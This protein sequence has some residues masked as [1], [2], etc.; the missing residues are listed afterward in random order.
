[1]PLL[2]L[3]S[4]NSLIGI[5]LP[6]EPLGASGRGSVHRDHC[7]PHVGIEPGYKERLDYGR[8]RSFCICFCRTLCLV[9]ELL[10]F[11]RG[12]DF[13]TFKEHRATAVPDRPGGL[14][15]CIGKARTDVYRGLY[16]LLRREGARAHGE[17]KA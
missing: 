2:H 17:K 9:D 13:S 5:R 7:S 14:K 10:R 3:R 8:H 6:P 11:R 1:M 4:R 12:D 16:P 15:A